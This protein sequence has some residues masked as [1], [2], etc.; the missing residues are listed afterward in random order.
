MT[1]SI[2]PQQNGIAERKNRTVINMART[3]LKSKVMPKEFWAEAVACAVYLSNQSPTRSLEKITPQEAWSGWKPSVKHLRVFGSS[4][5]V[6]VPEQKERSLMAG[7]RRWYFLAMLRALREEEENEEQEV[8]GDNSTPFTSSSDQ[9]P[10][11]LSINDFCN[12]TER[13]NGDH[14]FSLFMNDEP[15]SFEE[16]IK[17]KKWIQPTEEEIHSIEKNDTWELA[18]LPSGHEAIGVKWVYK[19][20]RNAKGEVE[21]HKMRLVA[22]GY[23]QK[24]GVDYEE[25][26]APIARLKT[27]RLLGRSCCT[28]PMADSSNGCEVR[29][30]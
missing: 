26:F 18:T 30:F 14:L 24:H 22:N 12:T 1:V 15:L 5:Y 4:C 25:V 2:T 20:K 9:S 11:Y 16:A 8:E 21:R 27:I 29:I 7:V 23:K 28:K 10:R 6:H 19:I 13:M 17:Q 3:M